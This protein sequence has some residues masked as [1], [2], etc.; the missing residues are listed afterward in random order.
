MGKKRSWEVEY[1]KYLNGDIDKLYDDLKIKLENKTISKDDYKQMQ[2]IENVKAN[3]SK[4]TNILELRNH[5]Q[6][7]LKK[8]K[9]EKKKIETL[10]AQEENIAKADKEAKK[11]EEELNKITGEKE[12]IQKD[13]K[14][15]DL[16][17]DEKAKLEQ[18]LV[19]LDGKIKENNDKFSNNQ[20]IL[21]GKNSNVSNKEKFAT[22]KKS[23][24]KDII[25]VS[26]KISKCNMVANNLMQGASWDSIDLKLENWKERYTSKEKIVE[27]VKGTS[28]EDVQKENTSKGIDNE[29]NIDLSQKIEATTEELLKEKEEDK[30]KEEKSLQ[31]V[32]EFEKKHPRLAKIG[33]WFKDK[34]NKIRGNKN[35]EEKD[36][37]DEKGKV[38]EEKTEQEETQSSDNNR[39]E[40][41]QYLKDVAEKGMK[42]TAREKLDA[43]KEKAYAERAQKDAEWKDKQQSTN[44]NSQV[45]KENSDEDRG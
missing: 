25:G 14:N 40:F 31:E 7:K 11:L 12:K 24:E 28:K 5:L 13:L 22:H 43:A 17:A 45:E 26:S 29:E 6:D 37:K 27:K 38:E 20:K 16:S 21:D 36:N 32:S 18:N 2:K 15:P 9:D 3:I 8:L 30:D 41:R 35:K 39:D 19:E 4:V 10:E 1:E 23:V 42:Q 34:W 44:T 33:K